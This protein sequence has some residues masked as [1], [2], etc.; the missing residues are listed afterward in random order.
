M[1]HPRFA[2]EQIVGILKDQENGLRKADVY[3]KHG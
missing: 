2:D 3:R 1:K